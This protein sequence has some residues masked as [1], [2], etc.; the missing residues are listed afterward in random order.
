MGRGGQ[1]PSIPPVAPP[2]TDI[3]KSY[4]E[5]T[6]YAIKPFLNRGKQEILK[7]LG[8]FFTYV[9]Y[10]LIKYQQVCSRLYDRLFV[11]QPVL[12]KMN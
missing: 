5:Y 12:N 7:N 8:N 2:L 9:P 1:F 11:G 3:H 10:N 6:V 4:L